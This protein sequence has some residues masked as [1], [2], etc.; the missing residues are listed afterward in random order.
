[1]SKK[2]AFSGLSFLHAAHNFVL[3]INLSTAGIRKLDLYGFQM[4]QSCLVMEWSGFLN[5]RNPKSDFQ[6][7][8]EQSYF[9]SLL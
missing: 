8:F 2:I 3:V 7:V 9:G 5:G 4:G 6:N 1:M